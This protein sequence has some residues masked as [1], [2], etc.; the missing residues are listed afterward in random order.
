MWTTAALTSGGRGPIAS[1][2]DDRLPGAEPGHDYLRKKERTPVEC[3]KSLV[4]SGRASVGSAAAGHLRPAMA[5]L[6]D[7]LTVRSGPAAPPEPGDRCR[8]PF[9]SEATKSL[10]WGKVT[11]LVEGAP[12]DAGQRAELSLVSKVLCPHPHGMR[13]GPGRRQRFRA[14]PDPVLL[15]RRQWRRSCPDPELWNA[16]SHPASRSGPAY[17]SSAGSN[18]ACPSTAPTRVARRTTAQ[19]YRSHR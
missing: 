17:S 10:E 5:V 3:A 12:G 14:G 13:P 2:P 9:P 19:G 16:R 15:T 4:P 7:H 1:R 18:R 11:R 8:H 6:S